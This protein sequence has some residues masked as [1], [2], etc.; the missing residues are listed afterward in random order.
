M[1]GARL[2]Y[3]RWLSARHQVGART[4][5]HPGDWGLP[6]QQRFYYYH[7][8]GWGSAHAGFEGAARFSKGWEF[9]KLIRA[10]WVHSDREFVAGQVFSVS[11]RMN[12]RCGAYAPC[13]V[14]WVKASPVGGPTVSLLPTLLALS[15]NGDC[16]SE[17]VLPCT[18]GLH[19]TN[20]FQDDRR[21]FG[22]LEM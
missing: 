15:I 20:S 19:E 3:P 11:K 12:N 1:I 4:G 17:Q 9:Y 2:H 8:N 5:G 13:L 16:C 22:R 14:Y 21:C 10:E 6:G 18:A 7:Q